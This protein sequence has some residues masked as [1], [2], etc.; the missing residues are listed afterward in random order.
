MV[1]VEVAQV[2][3]VVLVGGLDRRDQHGQGVAEVAA[4]PDQQLHRVVELGRVGAVGVEHR[5]QQ[6]LV[7]LARRP[8]ALSG[9]HPGHVA[10]E[11]VDLAVVAEEAERLG[12]LPGGRGVGRVALVEHGEGDLEGGVG[13]VGIEGGE[14][15]GRA[16]RLVGHRPG[17]AGG[18][19]QADLGGRAARAARRPARKQRRSASSTSASLATR[20][21]AC[22]M[23]GAFALA[24]RRGRPWSTGTRRQ[25]SS[26]SPSATS[27]CSTTRRASLAS[28][29][30]V[31]GMAT[32]SWPADR[33][34]S[35]RRRTLGQREQDARRR[36][37]CG[38]RR[39]PRRGAGGAR[40]RT[41]PRRGWPGSGG[42]ARRPRSRCH[43]RRARRG[44]GRTGG[45][46]SSRLR[47]ATAG[48]TPEPSLDNDV[49]GHENGAAWGE[50][51]CSSSTERTEVAPARQHP[52]GRSPRAGRDYPARPPG[53]A[54]P[55]P[56]RPRRQEQQ[57][58]PHRP[59]AAA[60]PGRAGSRPAG[61]AGR[62]PA[63]AAWPA[64][65]PGP[66]ARPG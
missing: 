18:Q 66:G 3:A 27:A 34:A 33:L 35:G 20:K 64:S 32:P 50:R 26:S 60:G 49:Q 22:S 47:N 14:L 63:P 55:P 7:Q 62:A 57:P 15:V 16:Q 23:A 5:P 29:G 48:Q 52:Y 11:G 39:R 40:A 46:P 53:T 10:V 31:E 56:R 21:T 41:G 36:R 6:V 19:V 38:R 13:Q 51:R 43:R 9:P 2:L 30:G 12:A 54:R 37:R 24:T 45:G 65:G 4:A 28:S 58:A 8:G 25:R 42:R 17:R 59:A 1:A 61:P 44:A